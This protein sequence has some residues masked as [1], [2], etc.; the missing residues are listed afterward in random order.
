MTVDKISDLLKFKL[1]IIITIRAKEKII[2]S[3]ANNLGVSLKVLNLVF[4]FNNFFEKFLYFFLKKVSSPKIFISF[5][6]LKI[7]IITLRDFPL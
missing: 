3:S 1:D 4:I 5:I 7:S 2:T 6:E